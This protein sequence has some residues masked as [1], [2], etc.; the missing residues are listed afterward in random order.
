ML[1]LRL[2]GSATRLHKGAVFCVHR[3]LGGKLSGQSVD[4]SERNYK[5]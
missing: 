5:K 4:F 3:A 1:L 2:V